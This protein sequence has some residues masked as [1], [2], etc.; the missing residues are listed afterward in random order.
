[1]GFAEVK[2]RLVRRDGGVRGVEGV[3]SRA[4]ERR[5]VTRTDARPTRPTGRERWS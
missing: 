1:M 5:P 2:S 4:R 3:F